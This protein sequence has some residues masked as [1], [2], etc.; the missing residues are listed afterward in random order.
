MTTPIRLLRFFL[1]SGVFF[2]LML[3]TLLGALQVHAYTSNLKSNSPAPTA[4]GYGI[5]ARMKIT[6]IDF[7]QPLKLGWI[8]NSQWYVEDYSIHY[9]TGSGLLGQPG[10]IVIY[11]HRR[12]GM[13]DRLHELQ[14]G[15]TIILDGEGQRGIY[16]VTRS[17]QTTADDTAILN[18]DSSHAL[19]LYTCTGLLDQHRWVVKAEMVEHVSLAQ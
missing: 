3:L 18:S 5:P 9:L 17:Y 15:T 13:F 12:D 16:Q 1:L 6:T 14:P 2:C 7:D 11:A 19:T 8:Q 10:N 4:T